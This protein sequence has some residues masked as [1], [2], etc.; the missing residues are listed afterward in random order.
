TVHSASRRTSADLSRALALT[1]GGTAT[2]DDTKDG[3]RG[4][5]GR[6]IRFRS[7]F[8]SCLQTR[9]WYPSRTIPTDD[10]GIK[11]EQLATRG[12]KST[13]HIMVCRFVSSPPSDTLGPS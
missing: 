11:S 5:G 3:A 9:V 13:P 1:T 4:G 12:T 8:H 7:R 2:P 6:R 10:F